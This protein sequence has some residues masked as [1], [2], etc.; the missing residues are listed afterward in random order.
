M[1]Q[2]GR[3]SIICAPSGV[4]KGI[5]SGCRWTLY[6]PTKLRRQAD[7]SLNKLDLLQTSTWT[8]KAVMIAL[9]GIRRG[10]GTV[11][12]TCRMLTPGLSIGG[13]MRETQR[14]TLGTS[15]EAGRTEA[16]RGAGGGMKAEM[17]A[18]AMMK[19]TRWMENAKTEEAEATIQGRK[20]M[21]FLQMQLR[22]KAGKHFSMSLHGCQT[23]WKEGKVGMGHHTLHAY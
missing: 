5:S 3:Q 19:R 4:P 11:S 16:I 13:L 17:G 10:R 15:V 8:Q 7:S 20:K 21:R 22:R 1:H 18:E 9:A 14:S 12:Q 6:P 23:V 2:E